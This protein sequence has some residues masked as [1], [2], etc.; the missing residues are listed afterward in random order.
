MK[1]RATVDR[2]WLGATLASVVVAL[3]AA[4]VG[5]IDGGQAA[6]AG[7]AATT[8]EPW[9]ESATLDPADVAA[10]LG[11]PRPT[12]TIVYVGFTALFRPG[13]VPGA[14][15]RGPTSQAEGLA[16]LRRWAEPLAR[17]TTIVI[18]C[19]CCP[20]KQCPNVRPAFKALAEM[21]FTNVRV[22][23][24]PTSFEKDWVEKNYPVEKQGQSSSI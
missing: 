20:F 4:R 21:G 2:F 14:T 23:V 3:C 11:G 18:Y 17:T 12:P 24:L 22:M 10:T 8:T 16:D 7:Q 5:A 6:S 13:H 19:G 15:F 1:T 9:P